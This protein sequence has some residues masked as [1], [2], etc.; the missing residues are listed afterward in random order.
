MVFKIYCNCT[1]WCR[2]RGC[3]CTTKILIRWKSRKSVCMYYTHPDLSLICCLPWFMLNYLRCAIQL[4]N[5][6]YVL[7]VQRHWP[8]K[9]P[10]ISPKIFYATN[11]LPTNFRY[12]FV[13]YIFLYQVAILENRKFGTSNFVFNKPSEK[14]RWAVQHG[15]KSAGSVLSA[16][17]HL[18]HSLEFWRSHIPAF[19]SARNLT[20]SWGRPEA[21]SFSED[22]HV[23]C[24]ILFILWLI[25]CIVTLFNC[26][27]MQ[28][29]VWQNL[30][31]QT[32]YRVVKIEKKAFL[33]LPGMDSTVRC[34][35]VYSVH[36]V[37]NW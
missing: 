18:P 20:P 36:L 16:P 35:K 28:Q 6:W 4:S 30:F 11:F 26:T 10:Q 19:L 12:L 8:L 21:P 22:I 13:R 14:I 3:K 29:N 33:Y 2:R 15:Q 5:K 37:Y 9:V 1:Q 25:I 32:L 34:L 27:Y 23:E 17:E 7:V 31:I 24:I